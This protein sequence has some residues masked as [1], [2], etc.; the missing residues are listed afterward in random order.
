MTGGS[1]AGQL[2]IT[3]HL[4]PSAAGAARF[5][6]ALEV[7]LR[8]NPN[9]AQ[10]LVSGVL[11]KHIPAP[12]SDVLSAAHTLGAA[13]RSACAGQTPVVIGFAETATGLGH[14]VAAVSAPD[15]GPGAYLHTPRRPAPDGARVV[16]FNEEHSHA[17]D[18]SLVVL[19]DAELRGDRPLVLV[20]DELTTGKTAVNAIRVLQ[21]SWPRPVYVLASL[22]DCRSDEC[23]AG[24]AKAAA[25]LGAS[26]VSVSLLDGRVRLPADVLPRARD[27]I[28]KLPEPPAQC[29]AA[30]R[31]SGRAPV[32]WLDVVLP[33]GMPA[34]ASSGWG[35]DQ[36]RAARAAMSRAAASLPV[37]RDDRTLVL[38]DER[39]CSATRSSCTCRNCSLPRSAATCGH[40]PRP[41]RL[42]SRSTSPGIR[43]GRCSRSV[44]PRTATGAP[45]PTTSPKART[46][47][48]GTRRASITSCS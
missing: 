9:R 44:R 3:V 17:V 26:V 38:G 19:D 47:T 29:S 20:D 10:L 36:E 7:G 32:C 39:S 46:P 27:F 5:A 35:R 34:I 14:G 16:R 42:R 33:D 21:A 45:T 23:R 4:A 12:V 25:E 18:Q 37:A 2:G 13:V 6:G 30:A 24:V 11:G 15:G 40:P 22:I 1:V 48:R 41:G 28:A 31:R 8:H 43:C